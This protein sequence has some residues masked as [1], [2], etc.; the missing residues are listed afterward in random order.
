[1]EII[2][3]LIFCLLIGSLIFILHKWV[4]RYPAPFP[5]S[6]DPKKEI[7]EVLFL[8]LLAVCVPILRIFLLTPWLSD[9]I[10]SRFF[11][12]LIY[13][14]VLAAVYI[15]IPYI[16]VIRNSNWTAS[17]LGFNLKVKSWSVT[18]FAI[19]LG[20]MSG[21]TAFISNQVVISGD[22][23]P[24]GT[25][26]LLLF[27][28][29]FIEEFFHRGIIQS[30]LERAI[31]QKKAILIGGILFGMTHI[32]FDIN[33]L[34][35]TGLIFVF[36]AFVLQTMLGWL[37]GIIYMKTRSLWPGIACHYLVNWLPS[38]LAGIFA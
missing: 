37:L 8:W 13:A 14:P 4:G 3:R 23:I 6:P 5:F 32:A 21:I 25:L 33:Q 12:E 35:D 15:A 31:G 27:N 29:D 22:P 28:N 36:L 1:M 34:L 18:V 20:L 19:A 17:D 30:K 11:V 26:V 10:D 9:T 24:A 7:R 38:I 16:F 2:W